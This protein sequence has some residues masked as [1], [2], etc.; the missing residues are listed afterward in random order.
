MIILVDLIWY[1][2]NMNITER[3]LSCL[4]GIRN[5]YQ[6][7]IPSSFRNDEF[8]RLQRCN[9]VCSH[10]QT[11]VFW[12]SF[13]VSQYFDHCY[14]WFGFFYTFILKAFWNAFRCQLAWGPHLLSYTV[15]IWLRS[16]LQISITGSQQEPS[17]QLEILISFIR[18][19]INVCRGRDR[20]WIMITD[21]NFMDHNAGYPL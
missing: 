16:C 6:R 3:L 12:F 4:P 7:L 1:G 11:F 21:D 9:S 19:T 18:K 15:K 14:C 8:A 13:G 20:A 10:L 17:S 2:L 5:W